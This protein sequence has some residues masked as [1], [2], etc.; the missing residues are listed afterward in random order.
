MNR[1]SGS[2]TVMQECSDACVL[3]T[4]TDSS[5]EADR[6]ARELVQRRLAACVHVDGPFTSYYRWQG[7]VQSDQEW[8]LSI[9]TLRAA[10]PE[11]CTWLRQAHSY[12]EPQIIVLP[13]S[14]GSSG[15]LRWIA[16]EVGR[17]S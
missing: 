14:A 7:E 11:L 3:M 13:I 6:L 17:E 15:Y 8:R 5:G 1:S 10:V 2:D 16:D 4:T 12:D 9:K